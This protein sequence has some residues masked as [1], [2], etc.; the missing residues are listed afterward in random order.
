MGDNTDCTL[1][2]WG[3]TTR[4]KMDRVYSTIELDYGIELSRADTESATREQIYFEEIDEGNLT[5]DVQHALKEAG[6]GYRWDWANG[7]NYA[8]GLF[9]YDP[10]GQKSYAVQTRENIPVIPIG[11]AR[12]MEYIEMVERAMRILAE[13]AQT[14]FFVSESTHHHIEIIAQNPSIASFVEQLPTVQ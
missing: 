9:I 10:I 11:D 3:I 8:E 13:G 4:E 6:L 12:N 1:Y 14:G 5:Y 7:G 2:L